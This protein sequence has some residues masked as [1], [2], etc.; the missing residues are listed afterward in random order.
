MRSLS[1]TGRWNVLLPSGV[2]PWNSIFGP[3]RRSK[4]N[5]FKYENNFVLNILVF[6]QFDV[7]HFSL[8]WLNKLFRRLW[9]Q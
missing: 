9:Y 2:L 4:Y 1:I 8:L 6:L 3:G 7:L 5:N